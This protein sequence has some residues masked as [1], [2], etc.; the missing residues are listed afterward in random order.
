MDIMMRRVAIRIEKFRLRGREGKEWGS[1]Y[2]GDDWSCG[3]GVYFFSFDD[4]VLRFLAGL[5]VFFENLFHV[6]E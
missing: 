2:N 5:L 4:I 1:E 6:T 3:S